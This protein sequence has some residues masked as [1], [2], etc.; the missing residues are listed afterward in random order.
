[1]TTKEKA[2]FEEGEADDLLKFAE[3]LDYEK[4]ID[5]YEFR[6]NLDALR[7]RAGKLQKEQDAFKDALVAEFNETA[8]DEAERSTSAGGSPRRM[9]DGLEVVSLGVSEGVASTA[10]QR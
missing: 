7:D 9:E 1:M 8:A 6:Q 5:N 3:D 4:Y 10:S 2:D